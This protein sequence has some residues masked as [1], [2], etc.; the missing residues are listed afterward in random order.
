MP[1]VAS[2]RSISPPTLLKLAEAAKLVAKQQNAAQ[3]EN[4]QFELNLDDVSLLN[5]V[6]WQDSKKP[7]EH[8]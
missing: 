1:K 2:K 7:V 3:P 4:V 6:S 8:S 5:S